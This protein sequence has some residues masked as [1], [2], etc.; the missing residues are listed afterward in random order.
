M[1]IAFVLAFLFRTFEA[2]AFVIPTGSMAPTLMGRHKDVVCPK[3]GCPYQ[4]SA[5]E[6]VTPDGAP[7]SDD[8]DPDRSR[9][10]SD[11]PLHGTIAGQRDPS[12]NGDR[13]LVSK[14]A[15]EF[16]EPQRWDVIVFK[17]PGDRDVDGT[18]DSRTNFIKRLVGLP[19]DTIR[20]QHGDVWMRRPEDKDKG[21]AA[22]K[23]ASPASRR[24]S[25]WPCFSRCS[26]TTTCRGSPSTAG[27]RVG[28]R[29]RLAGRR[30]AAGAW[31]T[32]DLAT[33]SIDGTAE[34]EQ[35]LRY[36]HLRAV[37]SAVA[38]SRRTGATPAA[39][40]RS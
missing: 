31:R 29:S 21:D 11:V 5:S 3:C 9:H 4:V 34:G 16:G 17:Y 37:V 7:Q 36:H 40:A 1:V 23:F 39:Q 19:G 27:P 6:E 22:A 20:I 12:Y 35:W 13:I 32:D 18:T 8:A 2:E 25:S 33:F 24:R 38:G 26:T 28:I 14:F 30:R 15:Y 10:L